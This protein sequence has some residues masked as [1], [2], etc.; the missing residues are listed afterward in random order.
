MKQQQL[1]DTINFMIISLVRE[2]DILLELEYK[3]GTP[4]R[5]RPAIED[6]LNYLQN[7]ITAMACNYNFYG[8]ISLN[9]DSIFQCNQ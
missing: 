1:I 3:Y 4:R 2:L 8:L 6:V 9:I 5:F 7:V